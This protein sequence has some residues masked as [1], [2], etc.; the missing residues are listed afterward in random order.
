MCQK[1]LKK[2]KKYVEIYGRVE[3]TFDTHAVCQITI[4]S[5]F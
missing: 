1:R 5:F 2:K 4:I 3:S